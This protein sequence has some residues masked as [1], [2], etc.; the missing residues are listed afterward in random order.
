MSA[1]KQYESA[2]KQVVELCK[3]KGLDFFE[4]KQNSVLKFL[5]EKF[6][7]DAA[8]GMLNSVRSAIF[9]ISKEKIEEDPIILRFLKDVF[10]LRPTAPKY[11]FTWDVSIV[12]RYLAELNPLERLPITE[13]T[14]K[15][16]MLMALCTAHRAQTLANI[17]I[18]NIKQVTNGMEIRMSELIKTSGPGRL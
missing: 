9:L 17:D 18:R 15:T 16:V 4:Q 1:V 2:L 11:T 13:L 5:S 10:K 12:L 6:Q 8:Y 3:K 7:E 14:E